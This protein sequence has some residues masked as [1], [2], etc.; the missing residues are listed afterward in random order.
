LI[1]AK[2]RHKS[3]VYFEARWD[4]PWSLRHR[5]TMG[6]AFFNPITEWSHVDV[7]MQRKVSSHY[8]PIGFR[9]VWEDA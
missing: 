8:E 3:E 7:V 6:V 1:T 4:M 2:Q 5:L 9:L